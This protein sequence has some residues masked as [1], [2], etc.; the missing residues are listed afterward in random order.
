[1]VKLTPAVCLHCTCLWLALIILHF[2]AYQV[3]GNETHTKSFQVV[4]WTNSISLFPQYEQMP[5]S[6]GYTHFNFYEKS[7]KW[8]LKQMRKDW[9]ALFIHLKV[10]KLRKCSHFVKGMDLQS[11]SLSPKSTGTFVNLIFAENNNPSY[12]LLVLLKADPLK[13]MCMTKAH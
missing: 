13:L 6:V 5:L 10:F 7:T 8:I 1:M 11:L 3:H 2:H 9:I 4:F 12:L